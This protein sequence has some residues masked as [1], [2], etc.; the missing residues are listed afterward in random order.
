VR[1]TQHRAGSR[2]P[3]QPPTPPPA[4]PRERA[5]KP[6]AKVLEAQQSL[7]TRTS[8]LRAAQ[9]GDGATG[10]Q[11]EQAEEPSIAVQSTQDVLTHAIN[12]M[13]RW[14][15]NATRCYVYLLDVSSP[16]RETNG[17]ESTPLWEPDFRKSRWFTRGWTLQ[18]LLAPRTVEFFCKERKRL[19]D[20]ASLRQPIHETTG[21]PVLALQ[22]APL[23][24]F[25]VDERLF[26]NKDRH[27]KLEEDRAYSMLGI[28]G[29][30]HSGY[31][32]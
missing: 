23:S 7:R 29:R 4:P 20:K 17:D 32:W 18:E 12:S 31:L 6:S 26:W 3:P 13:F 8:T 25:S 11:P 9:A 24:Q 22:G 21:V 27:T 15:R 1:H 30:L 19:G 28:F 10:T 14:Y 16:A 2:W 5:R